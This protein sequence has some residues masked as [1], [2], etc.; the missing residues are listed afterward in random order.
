MSK[1]VTAEQLVQ[2]AWCA[3]LAAPAAADQ[4]PPG[5]LTA[6]EVGKLLGKSQTRTGEMLLRAV[7]EGRCEKALFRVPAAG[8][9]RPVPHYKLK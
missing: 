5:W 7:S 4:V 2:S 9:V 6:R 8:T 3:A 1:R